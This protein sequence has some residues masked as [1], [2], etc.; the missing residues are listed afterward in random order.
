[1][2][3]C[4]SK[5]I[6][7]LFEITI[8]FF[9]MLVFSSVFSGLASIL[10]TDGLWVGI[11]AYL[12][13]AAVIILYITK[14]EKRPISYIGLKAP[15]LTDILKGLILGFCMFIVQQI[16]LLFMKMDYSVLAAAPDWGNIIIM[17][18]YCILCVGFV[19]ELIF[20]GFIL[21]KTQ[22][23]C[24]L[25]VVIIAVNCLL[26]YAFHWPPI[27][28]VFGEFFNIVVNTLFLCLYFYKSK[29]KS[30]IP[31][32][33]AHGFYDILAVYLLPAFLYYIS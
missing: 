33:V 13:T 31:L 9:L 11:I 18:L 30:L 3:S 23:L 26:F 25:K 14:V 22:E 5:R 24:K 4:T 16:P 8:C 19:E 6:R 21:Q 1:M 17:S 29:N 12:V 7:I 28:F 2:K 20:R 15:I 32:M 27:R 10:K